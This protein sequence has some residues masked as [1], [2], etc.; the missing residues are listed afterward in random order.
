M[1]RFI[2]QLGGDVTNSLSPALVTYPPAPLMF[3]KG[4]DVLSTSPFAWYDLGRL[5]RWFGFDTSHELKDT[6]PLAAGNCAGELGMVTPTQH[7]FGKATL[8]TRHP[9]QLFR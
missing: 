2:S 1:A 3:M 4:S 7:M 5:Q 9:E 8:I 6:T